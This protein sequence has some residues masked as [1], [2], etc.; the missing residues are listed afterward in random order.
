VL[1][2]LDSGSIEGSSST[3]GGGGSGLLLLNLGDRFVLALTS[4]N[5]GDGRVDADE[6]STP[7]GSNTGR[8]QP[9]HQHWCSHQLNDGLQR[10]GSGRGSGSGSGSGWMQQ[11]SWATRTGQDQYDVA[12]DAIVAVGRTQVG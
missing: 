11:M 4:C 7:D 10:D 6:K 1:S 5:A 12:E 2:L 8:Q 9:M 3:L